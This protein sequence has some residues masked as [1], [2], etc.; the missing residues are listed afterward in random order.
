MGEKNLGT[1]KVN[2]IID[3]GGHTADHKISGL[4]SV[5][6]DK[7]PKLFDHGGPPI[8]NAQEA[9]GKEALLLKCAAFPPVHIDL[10]VILEYHKN[11]M[12]ST[13]LEEFL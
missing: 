4:L 9:Q 6:A 7:S 10:H 13:A 2:N 5:G 12:V 11:P 3:Q 1:G 8:E